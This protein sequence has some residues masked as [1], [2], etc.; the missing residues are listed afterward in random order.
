[1][2]GSLGNSPGRNHIPPLM[3]NFLCQLGYHGVQIFHQTFI[4][5]CFLD[6]INIY[7][8]GLWVKK[9]VLYN[10]GESHLI[11]QSPE[12]NK[13]WSPLRRKESYQQPSDFNCSISCSLGVQSVGLPCRFWSCQPS[14]SY[15]SIPYKTHT[16]THT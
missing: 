10:M 2:S 11:N 5:R 14:Q 6:E 7:V 4:W 9:I 8:G 16:Y 3:I 12:Q 13:D 15:E 1:M